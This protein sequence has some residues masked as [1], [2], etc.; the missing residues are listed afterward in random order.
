MLSHGAVLMITFFIPV[1]IANRFGL[2]YLGQILPVYIVFYGLQFLIHFNFSYSMNTLLNGQS[3]V[4]VSEW[5]NAIRAR[6]TVAFVSVSLLF[7][8]QIPIT[9]LLS[10]FLWSLF[11]FYNLSYFF[12]PG[13]DAQ[14]PR[15]VV[16]EWV[17]NS[18]CLA[19]LLLYTDV[20]R[21]E[22]LFS[23]LAGAELLKFLMHSTITGANFSFPLLPRVNFTMIKQN[24]PFFISSILSFL[25]NK[26]ILLPAIFILPGLALGKFYM[27]FL[28]GIAAIQLSYPIMKNKITSFQFLNNGEID[29]HSL[30]FTIYGSLVSFV[31]TCGGYFLL[32][33]TNDQLVLHPEIMVPVFLMSLMSFYTIPK[34]YL[35]IKYREGKTID[36]MN[37]L[38]I[39]L[40]I[41]GTVFAFSS[42]NTIHTLWILM[43]T[44]TIYTGSL[45]YFCRKL[46]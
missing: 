33:T 18:I 31:W 45:H 29:R 26:I 30:K 11:R 42:G 16:N 40:Q 13:S 43:F 46:V 34:E 19:L 27:I 41:I 36:L 39:P 10:G 24:S 17:L 20:F 21:A 32:S 23:I 22:I 2:L 8:L 7:L 6:T 12:M 5:K 9:I 1:I 14:V 4:H 35:L 38:L 37:G 44:S 15:R 28:W 25:K 3:D